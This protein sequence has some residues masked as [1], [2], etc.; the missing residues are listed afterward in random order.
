MQT[1][2]FTQQEKNT[3]MAALRYYQENGQGEPENRS[4]AI[5]EIATNGDTETSMD[6]AGI[7]ALCQKLN[8]AEKHEIEI[9]FEH[10]EISSINNI[11]QGLTV[12]IVDRDYKDNFTYCADVVQQINVTI[13][14]SQI[15]S[16][17]E[18]P[19]GVTVKVL[20]FDAMHRFASAEDLV[21]AGLEVYI[22]PRDE[23]GDDDI[24]PDFAEVTR[25]P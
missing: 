7:D 23:D 13:Q 15:Q 2:T 5:H 20:D 25:W 17:E 11:P 14:S 9:L 3:I 19:E 21:E 8:I 24:T 6:A 22:S 16:V 10:G 12:E 1:I 18:V 4:D